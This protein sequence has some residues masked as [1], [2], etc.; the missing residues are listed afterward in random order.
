VIEGAVR[1]VAVDIR[2]GSPHFGASTTVDL[3]GRSHRQVW[4]PPGYAHGFVVL[5]DEADFMYACTGVYA[6]EHQHSILWNDPELGIDWGLDDPI[7]SDKDRDAPR[8]A[9]ATVLPNYI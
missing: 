5:S 2:R 9:G 6:P 3:D 7:L 8:L 1:D 4:I